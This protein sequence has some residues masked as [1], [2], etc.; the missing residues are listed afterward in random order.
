MVP[1]KAISP[2]LYFWLK[3][4]PDFDFQHIFTKIGKKLQK[5]S[6]RTDRE[7]QGQRPE[8]KAEEDHMGL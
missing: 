7:G 6:L 4:Y 8:G 3:Q 2:H 1:E 5:W